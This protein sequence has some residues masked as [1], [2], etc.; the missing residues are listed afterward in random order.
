MKRSMLL[1]AGL[2]TAFSVAARADDHDRDDDHE[3]CAVARVAVGQTHTCA[4]TRGGRLF[5]WGDNGSGEL[6]DGSSG[7]MQ[8]RPVRALL[9]G[10]TDIAGGSSVTCAVAHGNAYCWGSNLDGNLGNGAQGPGSL[11]PVLAVG[12][13]RRVTLG[14]Q[15]SCALTSSGGAK[16]WGANYLGTVGD[17]TI[18]SA[19]V[20][21]PTDVLGLGSGVAQIS[22]GDGF[23]TCARSVG[24]GLRCWGSNSIGQLGIGAINTNSATPLTVTLPGPVSDVAAGFSHTCAVVDHSLWCWG[25]AG[26]GALGIPSPPVF[27]DLPVRVPGLHDVERVA[28]GLDHTCAITCDHSLYCWGIEQ[29]SSLFGLSGFVTQSFTPERVHEP[30]NVSEVAVGFAHSCVVDDRGRL[31]CWGANRFGE[32]GVGDTVD[33]TTPTRVHLPCHE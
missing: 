2:M 26:D 9:D 15:H 12:G 29:N 24:G 8:T 33:R 13:A 25:V 20:L 32:L 18:T 19:N 11:V 31:Y 28:A 16:C 23:H 21:S 30:R 17:G 27:A 7:A 14:E 10:V 3:R 5:C 6:G 22:S 4:V 1:V